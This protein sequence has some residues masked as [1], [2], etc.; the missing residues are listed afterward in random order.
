MYTLGQRSSFLPDRDEHLCG[1]RNLAIESFSSN[2]PL[3]I[4]GPKKRS[5]KSG[6]VANKGY[7]KTKIQKTQKIPKRGERG[8]EDPI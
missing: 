1:D 5:T 6:T 3:K 2:N 7:P 4:T 8:G